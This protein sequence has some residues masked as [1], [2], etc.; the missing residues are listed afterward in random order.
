MLHI[1]EENKELRMGAGL[2]VT[3]LWLFVCLYRVC[4]SICP[5]LNP[6]KSQ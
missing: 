4:A 2:N 5:P 1:S 3:Q 6:L